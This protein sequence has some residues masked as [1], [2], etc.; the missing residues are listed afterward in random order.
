[1]VFHDGLCSKLTSSSLGI[2]LVM[3]S[4]CH[5]IPSWVKETK[6][7][8]SFSSLTPKGGDETYDQQCDV[9]FKTEHFLHQALWITYDD[10]TFICGIHENLKNVSPCYWLKGQL[11]NQVQSFS[12][13]HD[14][15]KF[16][17]YLLYHDGFLYV[18]NNLIQLQVLQARHDVL[19]TW[20]FGFNKTM[21]LIFQKY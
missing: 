19:A 21:E 13:V 10:K 16:W 9:I 5:H 8:I 4:I 6:H 20:H 14:K 2:I 1:M 17:N 11:N 15:F 18:L 3:I 7:I 12:S